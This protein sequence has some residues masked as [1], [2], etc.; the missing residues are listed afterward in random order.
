M[1]RKQA[2]QVV[3]PEPETDGGLMA[4]L[5]EQVK[6]S[7]L[8]CKQQDAQQVTLSDLRTRVRHLE[9]ESKKAKREGG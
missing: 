5:R 8:L 9:R 7:E 4:L 6:L 2:K 1:A 3:V